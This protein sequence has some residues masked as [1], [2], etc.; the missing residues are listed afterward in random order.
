M[1]PQGAFSDQGDNLR[2]KGSHDGYMGRYGVSHSRQILVQP[3]GNAI[4]SEDKLSTRGLKSPDGLIA[5]AY[6]IRFHLHPSVKA[7]VTRR[8]QHRHPDPA[9]R[10]DLA[11]QLERRGDGHRGKRAARR[12][13]RAAADLPS[14]AE[15]HDGRGAGGPHRVDSRTD[16]G[17]SRSSGRGFCRS[18]PVRRVPF[19]KSPLPKLPVPKPRILSSIPPRPDRTRARH[20]DPQDCPGAAV[21]QRQDGPGRICHARSQGHGVELVSTGG[22][23]KVLRDAGPHGDR[24]RRGHRQP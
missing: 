19:M 24:R 8:R 2:I 6:A 15:R 1:N 20:G 11:P 12:P 9:E 17:G 10:R 23:A 3:A 14:R 18:F 13:A 4:S 5:G 22:T 16:G 21:G 7:Q